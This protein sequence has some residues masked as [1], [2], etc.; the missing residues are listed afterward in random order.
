V[1][2]VTYD[3]VLLHASS[4]VTP[5]TLQC[6][7]KSQQPGKADKAETPAALLGV[8]SSLCYCFVLSVTK[9]LQGWNYADDPF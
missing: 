6:A 8:E 4:I 7:I 2:K 9:S 3:F 1:Q 5:A